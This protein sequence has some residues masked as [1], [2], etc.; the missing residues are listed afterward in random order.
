MLQQEK[1][2]QLPGTQLASGCTGRTREARSARGE[3]DATGSTSTGRDV[4]IVDPVDRHDLVRKKK[5]PQILSILD[6]ALDLATIESKQ[7]QTAAAA[8]A[9]QARRSST[10]AASQNQLSMSWIYG[11]ESQCIQVIWPSKI[12]IHRVRY[13]ARS[14]RGLQQKRCSSRSDHA[15]QRPRKGGFAGRCYIR[16]SVSRHRTLVGR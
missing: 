3:G 11:K 13:F 1:L 8:Q 9:A 7:R 15:T 12:W 4:E 2:Q 5:M 16:K 6:Q 14:P 10:A